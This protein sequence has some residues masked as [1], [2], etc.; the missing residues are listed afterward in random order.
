MKRVRLGGCAGWTLRGV[1]VAALAGVTLA[2]GGGLDKQEGLILAENGKSD[3][4]IVCAEDAPA[5]VREAADEL[6]RVFEASTGVKLAISSAP[7]KAAICVGAS[8]LTRRLGVDVSALPD[9]GFIIET[10]QGH[11]VIAGKDTKDN[12]RTKLNGVSDGTYYGVMAFLERVVGAR[13]LLP[14]PDGEDIPRH[15]RL[16]VA[17]LKIMDAPALAYRQLHSP[18]GTPEG[19]AWVRRL[20]V[21]GKR[22]AMV[23]DYNHSFHRYGMKE[24][25][26]GRPELMAMLKGKRVPI[27]EVK[28]EH[29]S[30]AKFCTSN[31]E[32]VKM[33][34]EGVLEEMAKTPAQSMW[35][36][37]PSDGGGWCE[38]DN[39]VALDEPCDWPGAAGSKSLS[40]RVFT[41]YNQVA[42]IVKEKQPGKRLGCFAYAAYN[43]P[44]A[45]P[46][47]FDP[48]LFLMLAS[49]PYYGYSLYR[50]EFQKEFVRLADGWDA[51]FPG[52]MGWMDFSVYTGPL[53]CSVGAPYPAGF[54]IMKLVFGKARE[55]KWPAVFWAGQQVI[56]YGALTNY[57]AA[58]M[59]WRP[60]SDVDALAAEWLA[61]AYGPGGEAMGK[62]N[63]LLE[64][65]LAA[66]KRSFKVTDGQLYQYRCVPEQV[67]AVHL[68]IFGQMEALYTE[69]LAKAATDSQRRRVEMFG[70]NLV[71]LHWHMRKAG[72]MEAP[73]KSVFYRSDDAFK[74]F[75]E[76]N[77]MSLA[78]RCVWRKPEEMLAP[79][80]GVAAAAPPS[81]HD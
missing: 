54:E 48:S 32:L 68:P 37:S 5:S 29:L 56:G 45:T 49:R 13:W 11:V 46:M 16:A 81:R 6:Q 12:E 57:V 17:P 8:D 25:L 44:P 59:L 61:R 1:A 24:K 50:P 73:E 80:L 65:K 3:F 75:A 22:V 20:G 76:K 39:C 72:W 34:A 78:I 27:E 58:K 42:R 53:K 79:K 71:V 43:Y 70:D 69:A 23:M 30:E 21:D 52:R 9:E 41:F 60:E 40:R 51:L 33:F 4:S 28:S 26:K 74:A 31:P 67:R 15:A 66:Y 19:R 35:S 55:K 2:Q 47:K 10:R 63:A 18:G 62:I 14:G 38:C 64:E 36:V 77:Y 7:A